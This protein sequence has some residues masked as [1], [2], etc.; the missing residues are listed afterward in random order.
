MASFPIE[1]GTKAVISNGAV[2]AVASALAFFIIIPAVGFI[3]W[4]L[5]VRRRSKDFALHPRA[6]SFRTFS[7]R[8]KFPK[9]LRDAPAGQKSETLAI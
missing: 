5:R 4:Y 1:D 8:E 9:P 2:A 7:G 6:Q 3:I